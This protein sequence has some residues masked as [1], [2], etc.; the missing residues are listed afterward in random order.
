[1]H[2][3]TLT[4]Q[5]KTKLGNRSCEQLFREAELYWTLVNDLEAYAPVQKELD[6]LWKEV[7][8]Q[9]FHDILPGSSIAWV[10]QD[11]ERILGRVADRLEA[12]ITEAVSRLAPHDAPRTLVGDSIIVLNPASSPRRE[13]VIAST[14]VTGSLGAAVDTSSTT[15]KTGD[16]IGDVQDLPGGR[17]AFVALASALAQGVRGW[18]W[19]ISTPVT[20]T[21]RSLSNEHL[22]VMWDESG[23]LTSIVS[24][25]RPD[26]DGV[27]RL[28]EILPVGRFG[29][30]LSLAPDHPVE[31]DAWDVERWTARR[32]E[33]LTT[34]DEIRIDAAGPLVGEVTV[35]RSF[36]RSRVST[37]YRLCAGSERLD[38]EFDIDW[39]E[40][41]KLLAVNFPLD[42]HT[43]TARCGIQFGHVD[44]P[45]H[46]NTSW[47]LAKFEVCAHRWVDVAEPS[48]G[49][50]ILNDGRYGHALH[51]D[52]VRVTLVRAANYPDP[53]ADRG[54][55]RTTLSVFPHGSSL[56]EV[57]REA[58]FLNLPMRV[59][60]AVGAASNS[61]AASPFI[62]V[63]S[64]GV[65]LSAVKL[66]DDGSGDVIV[67][68]AEVCGDRSEAR[69][70]A[71]S[72]V[73]SI[74][75]TDIFEAPTGETI[76]LSSSLLSSQAT[77]AL[78]P[79]QL[80]TLRIRRPAS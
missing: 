10:H 22:D 44:R 8:V 3:G 38:I 71:G 72:D 73:T 57:V 19:W 65:E 61:R 30:E 69:I 5:T 59:T 17:I 7:L 20:C 49:V 68:L 4:S 79:F 64:W 54:H 37:T 70:H 21:D 50:A 33:Q 77:V 14:D 46:E 1:M 60:P 78:R 2:R 26:L 39:H 32:S 62:G 76:P 40:D 53:E 31:Y 74:E 47:D 34:V 12:I 43:P 58:E 63:R 23:R 6:A 16:G 27:A 9:Q 75:L 45:R 48:F 29:A 28:R 24:K 25:P 35:V 56:V 67:R 80:L 52:S 18:S 36:G 42:V 41:E 66:A 11:A 51:G 13:V 15:G 55:H